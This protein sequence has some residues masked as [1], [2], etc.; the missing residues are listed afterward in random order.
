[1]KKM[2]VLILIGTVCVLGLTWVIGRSMRSK[3]LSERASKA[4]NQTKAASASSIAHFASLNSGRMQ[5][6]ASNAGSA[7][8]WGKLVVYINQVPQEFKDVKVWV[9]HKDVQAKEW[10][11]K[12]TGTQHVP[13]IQPADLDEF[14]DQVDEVI[15]TRGVE[16]VLQVPQQTVDY[17]KSKG[18]VCHIGETPDMIELFNRLVDQGKKVGGVFHSTC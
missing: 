7:C 6:S 3:N 17:V 16:R 10:N 12:A 1:M 2:F 8:G 13:G 18:K 9:G 15:L 11:W 5:R 4:V 14:I